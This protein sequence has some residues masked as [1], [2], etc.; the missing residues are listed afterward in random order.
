MWQARTLLAILS[1]AM[2]SSHV[3]GGDCCQRCGC[4][5]CVKKVCVLKV[6]TK[7][8]PHVTYGCECEDFCVAGP[9]K[10]CGTITEIDENGCEK[11]KPN[12][13]PQCA[14]VYTRTKLVKKTTE[15]EE[16]V[17]KWVVEYVCDTCA[18]CVASTG[19]PPEPPLANVQ[20]EPT[21]TRPGVPP[22]YTQDPR[23]A[24]PVVPS[25]KR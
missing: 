14:K 25:A 1:V 12:W 18:D 21:F 6:E 23:S 11:C 13:I 15:K 2:L 20:V 8:V 22:V 10:K 5:A 7:K 16:K 4:Q 19:L 17:Y 9:S 24:L 3:Y